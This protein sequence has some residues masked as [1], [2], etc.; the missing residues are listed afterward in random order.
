MAMQPTDLVDRI[1]RILLKIWDPLNVGDNAN[2]RDEYDSYI[3]QIVSMIIDQGT[4]DDLKGLLSEIRTKNIC[5]Q[6]EPKRDEAAAIELSRLLSR[7]T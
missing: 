3:P 5:V 1:R 7:E 2:L 4:V 6:P